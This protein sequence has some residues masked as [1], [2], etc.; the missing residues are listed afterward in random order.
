LFKSAYYEA[1]LSAFFKNS[2]S[3]IRF[4]K[5]YVLHRLTSICEVFRTCSGTEAAAGF[6]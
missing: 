1:L 2:N 6:L 4:A 3:L 5:T